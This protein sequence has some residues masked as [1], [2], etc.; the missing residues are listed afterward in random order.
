MTADVNARASSADRRRPAA[1]AFIH[2]ERATA[3]PVEMPDTT[4]PQEDVLGRRIPGEPGLWVF[5]L[6]DMTL[7]GVFFLAFVVARK[8][9]PETFAATAEHLDV[10]SGLINTIV[11][12]AS[13][14]CVLAAL[15]ALRDSR[16]RR[17]RVLLGVTVLFGI[18]FVIIKADEYIHLSSGGISPTTNLLATYYYV[19]TG[20]HLSHASPDIGAPWIAAPS[21]LVHLSLMRWT[22][23]G[24]AED[25]YGIVMRTHHI[26][27]LNDRFGRFHSDPPGVVHV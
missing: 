18:A 12:L 1:P 9:S 24:R 22:Y 27:E 16:V 2:S 23:G 17:A 5:I 14:F 13:S 20:I 25:G 19:L 10:W 4:R 8:Q 26:R 7:F 15:N 3:A 6:G 21:A 11:L